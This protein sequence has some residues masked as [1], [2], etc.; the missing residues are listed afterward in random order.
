M[1]GIWNTSR[2]NCCRILPY[3]SPKDVDEF[4]ISDAEYII[5]GS[6]GSP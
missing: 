1:L 6:V 5:H 2:L 4:S 3:E